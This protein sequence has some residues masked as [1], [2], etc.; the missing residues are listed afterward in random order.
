MPAAAAPWPSIASETHSLTARNRTAKMPHDQPGPAAIHN[1]TAAPPCK[2]DRSRSSP[3]MHQ[4]PPLEVPASNPGVRNARLS[5]VIGCWRPRDPE[6]M[7]RGVKGGNFALASGD[8][9][10]N[11]TSTHSRVAPQSH[12]CTGPQ[13]LNPAWVQT[14]TCSQAGAPSRGAALLPGS[15][16]AARQ[17]WTTGCAA[18]PRQRG[19]AAAGRRTALC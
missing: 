19:P 4:T 5:S 9:P 3:V 16:S 7:L 13:P 11:L 17:T 18:R 12:S 14:R 1:A 8:H 15:S 10:G 2:R 6:G